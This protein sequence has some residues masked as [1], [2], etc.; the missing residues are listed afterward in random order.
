MFERM[1]HPQSLFFL[2][3]SAVLTYWMVMNLPPF[4]KKVSYFNFKNHLHRILL[5]LFYAM[6]CHYM[7]CYDM[8]YRTAQLTMVV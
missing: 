6:L 1:I 8:L 4:F 5:L 7:L 2:V 3:P